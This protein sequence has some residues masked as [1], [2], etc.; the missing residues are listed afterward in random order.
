M[1]L[2]RAILAHPLRCT[3]H[4]LGLGW[5][6]VANDTSSS[7]VSAGGG[8]AAQYIVFSTCWPRTPAAPPH[9]LDPRPIGEESTFVATPLGLLFLPLPP[10]QQ[11]NEIPQAH[12]KPL[13]AGVEWNT[14][15][16]HLPCFQVEEFIFS[17]RPF[18]PPLPRLPTAAGEGDRNTRPIPC[19][20]GVKVNSSCPPPVL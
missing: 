20:Q 8:D 14:K 2:L 6:R 17:A 18:R 4:A 7:F 5:N 10:Q 16:P 12:R 13:R 9:Q 1:G 3:P 19:V 15:A 11:V